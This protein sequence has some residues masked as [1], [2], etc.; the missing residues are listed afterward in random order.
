MREWMNVPREKNWTNGWIKIHFFFPLPHFD[1]ITW[2]IGTMKDHATDYQTHNITEKTKLG[3]DMIWRC[4]DEW[5]LH[6]PFAFYCNN[7]S[8]HKPT[9]IPQQHTQPHEHQRLLKAKGSKETWADRIWVNTTYNT[10]RGLSLQGAIPPGI[11]VKHCQTNNFI[12]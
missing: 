4:H 3:F 11:W 2:P 12:Y 9:S 5:K 10:T 8:K 1:I 6:N 7:P